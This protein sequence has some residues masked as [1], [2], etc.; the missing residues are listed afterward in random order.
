MS[1]VK[2]FKECDRPARVNPDYLEQENI[3]LYEELRI[4]K[5]DNETLKNTI[6]KMVVERYGV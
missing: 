2:D 6:I 3:R 4:V 5:S 1:E